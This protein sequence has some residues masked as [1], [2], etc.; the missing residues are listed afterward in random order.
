MQI[1]KVLSW[2]NP[3]NAKYHSFQDFWPHYVK[4]HLHDTVRTIHTKA[5]L[6]G[7]AVGTVTTT[8]FDT[9]AIV[10][11]S[12]SLLLAGPGV[13]IAAAAATTYPKLTPSHKKYQG[14]TPASFENIKHAFYSI[15]GDFYMT[16]LAK[17][18]KWDEEVG[19]LGLQGL[20]DAINQNIS[21]DKDSKGEN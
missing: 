4:L 9:A 8:A 6:Q 19:R 20:S 13:F 7:L 1:N 3:R 16:W 2:L 10:Y 18:G 15:R 17:R 5:T 21:D 14:E 11:D 12:P